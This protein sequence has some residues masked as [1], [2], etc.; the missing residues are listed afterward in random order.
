MLL[1]WPCLGFS[2]L[3]GW[4]DPIC[5]TA[6]K[7]N[8]QCRKCHF[9][10]QK[11]SFSLHSSLCWNDTGIVNFPG[12]STASWGGGATQ[13]I[14][15]RGV[16][17]SGHKRTWKTQLN[18]RTLIVSVIAALWT[19]RGNPGIPKSQNLGGKGPLETSP[20]R[21]QSWIGFSSKYECKTHGKPF[22]VKLRVVFAA[23]F[24]LEIK[25]KKNS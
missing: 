21:E 10:A 13:I 24:R 3:S 17:E 8:F 19:G 15:H 5:Y 12:S 7:F 11:F 2:H 9:P 4:R 23:K 6:E 16:S 1:C 14:H 18:P 20:A 25:K 22:P